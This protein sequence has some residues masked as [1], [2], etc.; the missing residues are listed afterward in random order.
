MARLRMK[1]SILKSHLYEI[2][3]IDSPQCICGYRCEDLYHYFFIC[4]LYNAP[5]A[6]LHNKVANLAPFTLRTLLF[7]RSELSP[8]VNQ[9]I[10]EE[11]I[12]YV[13][14]SNRFE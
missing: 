5:R 2:R 12:T 10:Y 8:E 14:N 4:P 13:I 1:C 9:F 7:G 3:A 11:T 6:V